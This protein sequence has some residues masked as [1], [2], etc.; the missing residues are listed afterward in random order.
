MGLY[1]PDPLRVVLIG[2][3]RFACSAA[4]AL[5]SV[6]GVELA[7]LSTT[8]W[9][10]PASPAPLVDLDQ[11]PPVDLLVAAQNTRFLSPAVLAR[12]RLGGISYHPS[13][14]PLH[15]GRDA[16]RWTVRDRDRVAGGTVY[17]L[18]DGPIDGGDVLS[19]RWAFVRPDDTAST[20]W[21]REL[22]PLGVRLLA[23]AVRQIRDGC[24]PRVPQDGALATWEPAMDP[25]KLREKERTPPA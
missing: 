1:D 24:A 21:A 25:P 17:W 16:V 23:D 6:P 19:Q 22:F 14:L 8:R 18:D 2:E 5:L 13:L 7:A 20:L 11:L 10:E 4:A 9:P 3:G 15:R 12:A